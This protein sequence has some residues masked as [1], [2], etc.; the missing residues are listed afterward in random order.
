MIKVVIT[1]D[2]W[3]LRKGLIASVDWAALGCAMVGEA[4]NGVEGLEL[5]RR[6]NPDIVIT[7]IRMPMMDGLEMLRQARETNTFRSVILTGYSEF[8]Y[9]KKAISLQ[10]TEYL[11]KPV[12]EDALYKLLK[13]MVDTLQTDRKKQE[14]AQLSQFK[15]LSIL[16]R[17]DQGASRNFYVSQALDII[18][19]QFDQKLSVDTIAQQ[20]DISTSYLSRRFKEATAHS[21]VDY[22]NQYRV[23]KAAQMLRTGKYR[24]S[25]VAEQ[26]GFT[27]YKH[28]YNVFRDY[29]DMTPTEFVNEM[30]HTVVQEPNE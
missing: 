23:S 30:G 8:E 17:E 11:L 10:V 14:A 4:G 27:N 25:E 13:Q 3:I 1:E 15:K 19:S 28:F 18:H 20:L 7:D 29:M 21:F 6:E 5:I 12:D 22:L 24:V 26:T 16:L 9:A 2:E